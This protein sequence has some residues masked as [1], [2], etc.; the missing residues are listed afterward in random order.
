MNSNS[1]LTTKPTP[2]N[3]NRIFSHSRELPLWSALEC[4]RR[5]NAPLRGPG[6]LVVQVGQQPG[7]SK[8]K[9]VVIGCRLGGINCAKAL[10]G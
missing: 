10:A 5:R 8:L 6:T 9:R 1:T 4:A 7:D 2:V 3:A